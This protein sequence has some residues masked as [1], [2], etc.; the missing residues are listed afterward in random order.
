MEESSQQE[1][2]HLHL[3]NIGH[4]FQETILDWE[5]MFPGTSTPRSL[6]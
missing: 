2:T 3:K 6:Q 4:S 1:K 5:D